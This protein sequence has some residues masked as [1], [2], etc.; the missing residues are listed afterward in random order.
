MYFQACSTFNKKKTYAESCSWLR[1][2]KT[3]PSSV[4]SRVSG[5]AVRAQY[6]TPYMAQKDHYILVSSQTA[7]I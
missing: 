1:V 2:H 4:K 7:A 5:L 6:I 3:V